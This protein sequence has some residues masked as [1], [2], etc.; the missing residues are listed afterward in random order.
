MIDKW[1][2]S[3][4]QFVSLCHK[5][6][7]KMLLVGGAAVN[8]HGYQRHSADVDF[9]IYPSMH[10]LNGLLAVINEMGYKVERFPEKVHSQDQNISLKFSPAD[11]DIEL[12]TRF[13]VNKTFDEAY[14]EAIETHIEGYPIMRLKV[15]SLEDLITSKIKSGRPKDLL[16]VQQLLEINKR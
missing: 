16:D 11:F 9:W 3:V 15:I 5:H 12:I 14:N 6:N 8:F 2:E 1:Q 7:V 13:S 4:Q 10:N